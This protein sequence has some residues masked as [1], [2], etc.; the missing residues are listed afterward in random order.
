MVFIPRSAEIQPIVRGFFPTTE[1]FIHLKNSPFKEV[2]IGEGLWDDRCIYIF[3]GC[4]SVRLVDFKGRGVRG[5]I[6]YVC[7]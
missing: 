1:F 6:K 7:K 4:G 3:F 2:E 5:E